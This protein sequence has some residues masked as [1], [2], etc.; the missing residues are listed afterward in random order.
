MTNHYVFHI[1]INLHKN[2]ALKD[3]H[4]IETNIS[5]EVINIHHFYQR[6]KIIAKHLQITVLLKK[7]CISIIKNC[8]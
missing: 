6:L 8:I 2:Q 7:S 3:K 5:I 4:K 1:V